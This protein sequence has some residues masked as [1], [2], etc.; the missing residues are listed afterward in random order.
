MHSTAVL[1]DPMAMERHGTLLKSSIVRKRY[2]II[3]QLKRLQNFIQL[4]LLLLGVELLKTEIK[5]P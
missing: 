2:I 1:E 5:K 4:L 3:D